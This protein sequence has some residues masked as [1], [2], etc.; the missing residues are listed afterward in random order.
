MK[1]SLTLSE[2]GTARKKESPNRGTLNLGGFSNANP[3]PVRRIEIHATNKELV[4][5]EEKRLGDEAYFTLIYEVENLND[6]PAF[7]DVIT[8]DDETPASN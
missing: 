8:E 1:Y 4:R 6:S 2:R 7:F 3:P 5:Y